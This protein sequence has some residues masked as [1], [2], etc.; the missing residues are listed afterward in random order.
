MTTPPL[1]LR[2]TTILVSTMAICAISACDAAD[3]PA[4]SAMEGGGRSA[5]PNDVSACPLFQI[6]ATS[7]GTDVSLRLVEQSAADGLS[8]EFRVPAKGDP[9]LDNADW[10]AE[11][12]IDYFFAEFLAAAALRGSGAIGPLF[13]TACIADRKGTPTVMPPSRRGRETQMSWSVYFQNGGAGDVVQVDEDNNYLPVTSHDVAAV[14]VQPDEAGPGVMRL[15]PYFVTHV[16]FEGFDDSNRC[17]PDRALDARDTPRTQVECRF[18]ELQF[19]RAPVG[20][21]GELLL[22]ELF[23]RLEAVAAAKSTISWSWPVWN[24]DKDGLAQHRA[25]MRAAIEAN[26]GCILDK[27]EGKDAAVCDLQMEVSLAEDEHYLR[28]SPGDRNRIFQITGPNG[29]PL[30]ELA[31]LVKL[32]PEVPSVADAKDNPIH[33]WNVPAGNYT[34][35][36]NWKFILPGSNSGTGSFAVTFSAGR[37]PFA[38]K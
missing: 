28:I 30:E 15:V 18:H 1:Q 25:N 20:V 3:S 8:L 31:D 2:T 36:G 5:A 37:D 27:R 29:V 16:F 32:P 4:D 10:K 17:G 26:P 14:V 13:A 6:S 21:D 22:P 24:G 34:V 11:N 9:E 19:Q 38:K 23:G 12:G 33:A 7:E 35:T